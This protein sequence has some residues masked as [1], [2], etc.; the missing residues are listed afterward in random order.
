MHAQKKQK[1]KEQSTGFQ[2][3]QSVNI[4]GV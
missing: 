3:V 2:L 1:V 4:H